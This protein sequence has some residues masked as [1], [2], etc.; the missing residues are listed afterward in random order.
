MEN[1][2]LLPDWIKEL[3]SNVKEYLRSCYAHVE[4]QAGVVTPL[5][6]VPLFRNLGFNF[7]IH[8][9]RRIYRLIG[10]PN[11][12]TLKDVERAAITLYLMEPEGGTLMQALDRTMKHFKKR[13]GQHGNG[14]MITLSPRS[15]LKHI[16][17]HGINAL[18]GEVYHHLRYKVHYKPRERVTV[19]SLMLSLIGANLAIRNEYDR[20]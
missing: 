4:R 16:K 11:T 13:A 7:D 8:G 10:E 6:L 15:F 14:M 19:R 5:H 3:P 12:M 9:A 2:H 20:K 18:P 1:L 17:L